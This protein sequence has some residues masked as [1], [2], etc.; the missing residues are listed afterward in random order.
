M[1]TDKDWLPGNHEILYKQ[2]TQTQ[3]Y[4]GVPANRT[5]MGLA[6]D[7]PLGQWFDTV[8]AN[9]FIRYDSAHALW[10]DEAHRTPLVTTEFMEA[11]KALKPLYR[12]LYTGFLKD[13]PL[14]TDVDLQGMGLPKRSGGS[15]QHHP[16]P[17]TFVEAFVILVGVGIIEV[18]FHEQ[19]AEKKS[20]PFG[21]Q[22]AE[23]IWAVLHEPP[24]SH[25]EL[26]HSSFDTHTP[27]RLTFP[28]EQRG[29]TLY[30]A[31]RWENTTGEKGPWNAIQS[32]VIP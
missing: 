6:A 8:F 21:V 28:D 31:L 10:A 5:R 20:K 11:E 30:F 24:A 19:G 32:A 13:N 7:T 2:V 22:G 17:T 14:V 15:H 9:A 23:M 29:K 3:I 18:H 26:T 12:Q 27:F 4:L 1:S 16:V 25:E